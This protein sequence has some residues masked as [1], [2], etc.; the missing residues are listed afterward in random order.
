MK[1]T[2][3]D[4]CGEETS[5]A[6]V[7]ESTNPGEDPMTNLGRVYHCELCMGCYD[8]LKEFLKGAR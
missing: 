2:F 7:I 4:R 6:R 5:K 1:K 8:A 3:C